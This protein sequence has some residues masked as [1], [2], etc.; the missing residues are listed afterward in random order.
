MNNK[1]KHW[2]HLIE[3]VDECIYKWMIKTLAVHVLCIIWKIASSNVN[4]YEKKCRNR[5]YVKI[6]ESGWA[7]NAKARARANNKRKIIIYIIITIIIT[8]TV[9][10]MKKQKKTML[11]FHNVFKHSNKCIVFSGEQ[12]IQLWWNVG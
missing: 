4:G 10:W 3:N 6:P 1:F 11:K 5:N 8:V 7:V 9:E 12:V 2:N